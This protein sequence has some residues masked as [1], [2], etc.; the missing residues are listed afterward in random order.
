M[1]KP[2]SLAFL[3]AGVALL[4]LG[5]QASSSTSSSVSR[6]FTGAP[7]HE[8]VWLLTSAAVAIV[9]GLSGFR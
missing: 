1:N 2:V 8:A 6:F 3:A 4:V 5:V 7:T 9:I